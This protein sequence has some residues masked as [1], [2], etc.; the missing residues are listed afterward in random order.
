MTKFAGLGPGSCFTSPCMGN[1][2]KHEVIY[3]FPLQLSLKIL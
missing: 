3:L 1:S 2:M